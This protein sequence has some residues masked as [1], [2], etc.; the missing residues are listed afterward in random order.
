MNREHD[1][2]MKRLNEM[3][4]IAQDLPSNAG[5]KIFACIYRRNKLIATGWNNNR[6]H[7]FCLPFQKNEK[8]ESRFHAETHAIFNAIKRVGE[9]EFRNM[10]HKTMYIVRA[11]KRAAGESEFI[12]GNSSPC[13]GCAK[14]LSTYR[15]ETVYSSIDQT[16]FGRG[17]N[18]FYP[19]DW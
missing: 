13:V 19:N 14:A 3:F 6:Q 11:K 10:T 5:A 16:D 2:V 15:F 9:D 7:P 4:I 8:A 1:D 18:V 17:Y 12:Y